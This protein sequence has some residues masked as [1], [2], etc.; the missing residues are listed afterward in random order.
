[1]K[2]QAAIFLGEHFNTAVSLAADVELLLSEVLNAHSWVWGQESE[3]EVTAVT[4]WIIK[5]PGAGLRW[6]FGCQMC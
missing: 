4:T 5:Q 2:W 3:L 1:M 6:M